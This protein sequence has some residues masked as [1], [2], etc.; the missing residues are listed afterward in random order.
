MNYSESVTVSIPGLKR[1]IRLAHITDCHIS[2]STP[3]SDQFEKE[4]DERAK[5]QWRPDGR[6][7]P[8]DSLCELLD[9]CSQ[10]Q[11]DLTVMTGDMVDLPFP[12]TFSALSNVLQDAQVPYLYIFGNHETGGPVSFEQANSVFYP[13]YAPLTQGKPDFQIVGFDKYGNRTTENAAVYVVGLDDSSKKVSPYHFEQ[14]RTL[15]L[16]NKPIILC[17]HIPIATQNN[18]QPILDH[19]HSPYFL[20]GYGEETDETTLEFCRFVCSEQSNVAAILCGHIHFSLTTEFAPGRMQFDAAPGY[21]GFVRLV[22]LVPA[23]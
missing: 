12:A 8:L 21:N 5:K 3:Q 10:T 20:L 22:K 6:P 2:A 16:L 15:S 17:I 1:E 9:F 13:M 23:E 18:F 4:A 14:L 7:I 11:P 19:W